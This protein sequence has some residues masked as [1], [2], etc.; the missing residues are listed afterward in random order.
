MTRTAGIPWMSRRRGVLLY[1]VMGLL[2]G[3]GLGCK[4]G[5]GN[6]VAPCTSISFTPALTSPASGDVSLFSTGGSCDMIEIHVL[7]TDL[8]RIFTVG[9]SITYP[10]SAIAYQGFTAGPLLSQGSPP[11]SPQFFV[12]N[13]SPGELVVSGTLFRPDASVSAVGSANFITLQF[14]RLAGGSGSV[15]FDM[16]GSITNQIIDEN[17]SVVSASFGP[18]HGGAIQVP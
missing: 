4:G 13:P 12:T 18:G 3:L 9:F 10:A 8:S 1:P 7:V 6:D 2:L 15:D 14:L 11:T 16:G 5:G 17:G